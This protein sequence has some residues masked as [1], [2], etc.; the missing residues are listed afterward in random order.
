MNS[1]GIRFI[2]ENLTVNQLKELC[3]QSDLKIS[4]NK[5][6]LLDRL[7]DGFPNYEELLS[8]FTIAGLK[9]ICKLCEWEEDGDIFRLQTSG[10]KD[11]LIERISDYLKEWY[12]EESKVVTDTNSKQKNSSEDVK[13]ALQQHNDTEAKDHLSTDN[14]ANDSPEILQALKEILNGLLFAERTKIGGITSGFCGACKKRHPKQWFDFVNEDKAFYLCRIGTTTIVVREG[15]KSNSSYHN[16]SLEEFINEF[17]KYRKD[18]FP[19]ENIQENN[20]SIQESE[21]KVGLFQKLAKF[22]QEND[23]DIKHIA[24]KSVFYLIDVVGVPPFTIISKIGEFAYDRH[25][26]KKS[27]SI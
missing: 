10:K 11:E 4:G 8:N 18:D 2:L 9:E 22:F 27:E 20:I 3:S 26:S 7:Q 6:D 17:N 14:V 19:S 25:K 24:V 15:D 23:E 12:G 16:L 21:H 5:N 13:K 1:R